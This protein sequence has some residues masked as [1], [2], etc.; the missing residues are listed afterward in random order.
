MQRLGDLAPDRLK[1]LT[2]VDNGAD[3]LVQFVQ[4]E[5]RAV[6]LSKKPAVDPGT[7]ALH[8]S[9]E[10]GQQCHA[11]ADKGRAHRKTPIGTHV[12][13][14]N[15]DRQTDEDLQNPRLPVA[16]RSANPGTDRA[17]PSHGARR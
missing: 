12:H 8:E 4:D 15:Y 16:R 3:A 11:N 2:T 5:L 10:A 17:H 9:A 14:G 1:E 6:G 13:R 7:Q